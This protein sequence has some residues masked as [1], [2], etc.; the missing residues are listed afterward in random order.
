MY[1]QKLCYAKQVYITVEMLSGFKS[2][3]RVGMDHL[4]FS[5][6][7]AHSTGFLALRIKL[8]KST[9]ALLEHVSNSF[10]QNGVRG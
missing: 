10:I 7:E 2:I 5:L 3:S 4:T 8:L 9:S 1:S 6:P